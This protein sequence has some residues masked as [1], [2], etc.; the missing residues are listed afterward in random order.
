MGRLRLLVAVPSVCCVLFA[1]QVASGCGPREEIPSSTGE[2]P[3]PVEPSSDS[4]PLRT[5]DRLASKRTKASIIDRF[6]RSREATPVP[7]ALESWSIPVGNEMELEA[8]TVD[9]VDAQDDGQVTVCVVTTEAAMPDAVEPACMVLGLSDTANLD[10]LSELLQVFVDTVGYTGSES[11]AH[12]QR[13]LSVAEE[14]T[15][16]HV[17]VFVG[18]LSGLDLKISDL[19]YDR[20]VG[21]QLCTRPRAV[22]DQGWRPASDVLWVKIAG[23]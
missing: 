19:G 22:T 7:A 4:R 12:I 10:G 3:A 5:A 18:S 17:H 20:H 6:T 9:P 8:A 16:A 2:R 23:D 21:V 14:N 13:L 1:L 15:P 11:T